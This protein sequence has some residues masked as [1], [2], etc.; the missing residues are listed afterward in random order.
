MGEPGPYPAD[1]AIVGGRPRRVRSCSA[2]SSTSGCA[3]AD[4][5]TPARGETGDGRASGQPR[6]VLAG[7]SEAGRAADAG[8]V[9][10]TSL[11]TTTTVRGRTE[12]REPGRGF[13]TALDDRRL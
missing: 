5:G 1:V 11:P 10:A 7:W 6:S 4:P 13:L 3:A 2:H 8:P 12:G 9:T